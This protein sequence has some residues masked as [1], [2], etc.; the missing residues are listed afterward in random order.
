MFQ[1]TGSPITVN[2]DAVGWLPLVELVC[3]AKEGTSWEQR[4]DVHGF[5]KIVRQAAGCH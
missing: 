4:R 5:E 1:K 2:D 3:R